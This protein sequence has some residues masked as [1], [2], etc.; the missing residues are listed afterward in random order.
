MVSTFLIKASGKQSK[1]LPEW[2]FLA[3][4]VAVLTIKRINNE[5]TEI[6]I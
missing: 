4:F 2:L 1:N 3:I 5:S 6:E